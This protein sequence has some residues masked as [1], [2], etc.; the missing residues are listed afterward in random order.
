MARGTISWEEY[1][2]ALEEINYRGYLTIWPDPTADPAQ[3]V[4][5]MI[6]LFSGF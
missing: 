4:Q 3:Q 2:G 6:R 5:S 1:L